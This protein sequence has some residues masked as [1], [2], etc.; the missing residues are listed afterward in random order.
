MANGTIKGYSPEAIP[1]TPPGCGNIIFRPIRK[2][3]IPP[4]ILTLSW[5]TFKK[6]NTTCPLNKKVNIIIN[7]NKSS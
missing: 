5:R 3:I 7:E 4:A 6:S 1:V 2:R